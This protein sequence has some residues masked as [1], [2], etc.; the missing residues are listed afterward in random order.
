LDFQVTKRLWKNGEVK[1]NVGDILNQFQIFYQDQDEN[2][3]YNADQDT[4]IISSRYG[5]NVSLS[6]SYTF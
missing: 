5:S 4:K 1:L 2:G 6:F 3:K